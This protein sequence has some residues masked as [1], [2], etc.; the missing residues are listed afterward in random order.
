MVSLG[1]PLHMDD[2]GS[3]YSSISNLNSLPFHMLKLD[4]SLVD[5]IGNSRGNQVLRHIISL[6]H[7]LGMDVLAE[8]VETG[9]Q[10]QFLREVGCDV[11][12]GFYF[13][14]PLPEKTFLETMAAWNQSS[15]NPGLHV[16]HA[17]LI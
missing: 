10:V 9:E 6:A 13:S 8:G 14:R 15:E 7:G 12:Q 17:L 2:F 3:G 1:F 4:K 11:I 5:Y 16:R